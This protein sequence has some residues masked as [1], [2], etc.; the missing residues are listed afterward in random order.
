MF[1]ERIAEARDPLAGHLRQDDVAEL[2]DER[3]EA[4]EL[5]RQRV[6]AAKSGHHMRQ[7]GAAVERR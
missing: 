6:R 1:A 4:C 2:I 3:I 7:P 5:G